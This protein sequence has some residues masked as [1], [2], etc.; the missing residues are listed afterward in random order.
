MSL[1][2]QT[3]PLVESGLGKI[4]DYYVDTAAQKIYGP[5]NNNGWPDPINY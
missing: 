4:G 3:V 2:F 1:N 5:K